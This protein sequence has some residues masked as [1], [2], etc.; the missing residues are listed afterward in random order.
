[1]AQIDVAAIAAELMAAKTGASTATRPSANYE[2][3]EMS[4]AYEV[5]AELTR[6]LLAQGH[7]TNG[8]KVGFTNPVVWPRLN[9]DGPIW[10]YTYDNTVHYAPN[11][12]TTLALAG[13]VAPKIEPEIVFKLRT[14]LSGAPNQAASKVLEAVE[15]MALGFEI[16]DCNYANWHFR[17]AD[18]VADFGFHAALIIGQTHPLSETNLEILAQQLQNLSLKLLKNGAVEAEGAG[19]NVLGSPALSLAGVAALVSRQNGGKGLSAGEVIT[20]GTLTDAMFVSAG[21]RWQAQPFGLDLP[22]LTITFS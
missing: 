3:F 21:E 9:L 2:N 19:Q 13:M 14:D 1:M 8:R 11:N 18:M 6:Q 7:Q 16:V 22:P 12:Q 20:T 15:W 10:S 5:G 17:A 4:D